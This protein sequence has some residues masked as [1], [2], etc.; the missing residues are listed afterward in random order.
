MTAAPISGIQ[1]NDVLARG[2]L[3]HERKITSGVAKAERDVVISITDR[4]EGM[5]RTTLLRF[6]LISVFL[7]S[8]DTSQ[9]TAANM[10]SFI[11]AVRRKAP[12]VYVGSVKEVKQLE[13]TK[14]DI[15][16]RATVDVLMVARGI[17]TNPREATIEYSSY[18]D[19]T[20]MLEGGPQYQLRP[21]VKVV[22]F[23][24]S[25]ASNIPPGYLIQGS[26]EELLNRVEALRDAL[27]HMS[28]DQLKVHE[29]DEEDRRVQMALCDKLSAYFRTSK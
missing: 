24:T 27:S 4:P 16:T 22:V 20:P 25:F 5:T 13:R 29:I 21:G 2:V 1:P 8:T 6:A 17:N 15:K 12:V 28:S 19:K 18:D 3:C 7:I 23:A 26:R 9:V 14:F 11:E 10:R